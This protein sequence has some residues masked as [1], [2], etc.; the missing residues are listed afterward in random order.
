MLSMLQ[1]CEQAKNNSHKFIKEG[2]ELDEEDK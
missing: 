1:Q 2:E